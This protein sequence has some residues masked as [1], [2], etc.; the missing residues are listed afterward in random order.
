MSTA[1]EVETSVTN[2]S[3]SKDYLHPDDH[4]N[5]EFYMRFSTVTAFLSVT[6]EKLHTN[7]SPNITQRNTHG[8]DS[9]TH[10]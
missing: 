1:Q 3:L 6:T 10:T 5:P 4:A 9:A 7:Q 8:T 2:N